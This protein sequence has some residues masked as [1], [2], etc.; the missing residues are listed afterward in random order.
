[1]LA[2]A[3]RVATGSAGRSA[4]ALGTAAAATYVTLPAQAAAPAPG[5]EPTSW[6]SLKL[7]ESTPLTDNTAIYR[8]AFADPE[9]NSGMGVASCLL[10]KAAIGSEKEDGTRANVMRP[11]TPMSRPDAKGHLD[12]AVKVYPQGKMSQHI[13]SLRPGDTLDFKGP[14]LKLAYQPNQYDSIGMVAGGLPS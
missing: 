6:V 2:R 1:M 11:Y 12:L 13:G 3:L 9:A 4:G 10:V 8:F 7:V 14:I 5:L